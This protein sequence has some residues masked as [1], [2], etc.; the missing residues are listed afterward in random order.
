MIL[1]LCGLPTYL[2]GINAFK[3]YEANLEGIPLD[4]D[5]MIVDILEETI[6][7]LLKEDIT[8]KFIYTIPTFQNPAGVVMSE[9]R[10]KKL[11][12]IANEL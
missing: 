12:D 4:K 3:S 9:S 7:K 2:G 11:I 8:P 6:K 10:R 5:G 1:Q